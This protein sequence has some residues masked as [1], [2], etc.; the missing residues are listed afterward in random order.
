M[1]VSRHEMNE[2]VLDIRYLRPF[3][4]MRHEGRE[5]QELIGDVI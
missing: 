3:Q 1:R 2:S 4:H 5:A